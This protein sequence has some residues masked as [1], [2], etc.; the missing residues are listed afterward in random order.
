MSLITQFGLK[1]LAIPVTRLLSSRTDQSLNS[2]GDSSMPDKLY[3]TIEL[4]I[5]SSEPAVLRSYEKFISTAASHMGVTVGDVWFQPRATRE[6]W[7]SVLK[8]IFI[9]RKH[10]VQYEIRSYHLWM[11]LHKLTGST[12]DTFI[13]YIQ[14]MLPEGVGLKVTKISI[15]PK[16]AHLTQNPDPVEK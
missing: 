3:K 4:E 11:K 9:Y 6:R 10:L 8:S 1:R 2:Y 7:L 16:P 15:E 13:E 12:A 5:K 14:R